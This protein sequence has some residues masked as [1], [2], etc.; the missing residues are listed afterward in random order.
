MQLHF[1]NLFKVEHKQ[2]IFEVAKELSRDHYVL[3][4]IEDRDPFF[5]PGPNANAKRYY[6]LL[7][8]YGKK[9]KKKT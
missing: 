3:Q 7:L 1:G 6:N 4:K 9:N 8:H 5:R 2:I